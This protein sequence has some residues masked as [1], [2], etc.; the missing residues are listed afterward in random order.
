MAVML[1]EISIGRKLSQR[2]INPTLANLGNGKTRKL[3]GDKSGASV[4]LVRSRDTLLAGQ[5]HDDYV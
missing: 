3:G 1:R 5:S 4:A 2:H